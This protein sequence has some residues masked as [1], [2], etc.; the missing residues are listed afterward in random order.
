MSVG[1]L[2]VIKH[3]S[4]PTRGGGGGG[5]GT[6]VYKPFRYVPPKKKT[7]YEPFWSGIGFGFQ[8]NYGSVYMNVVIVSI[9]NE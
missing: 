1:A 5:G 2:L 8:G 9:G 3:L 7:V 6:P 4:Y